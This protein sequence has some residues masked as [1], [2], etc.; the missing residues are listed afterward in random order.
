[1]SRTTGLVPA[2]LVAV[3]LV[4]AVTA[5]GAAA[6]TS[7]TPGNG[8][9]W[10]RG[11]VVPQGL[12]QPAAFAPIGIV[13]D[14]V[15]GTDVPD[16]AQARIL[17]SSPGKAP[18]S[19]H[20]TAHGTEVASVAAAKA[21]GAGVIGIAPGAP[22]LSYGYRE[23]TGQDPTCGEVADGIVALAD[24][25]AKVINLS[26]ETDADCEDVRL[27]IGAAYGDGVLVVAAAGNAGDRPQFPHTYP[28]DDPH[29]LTVGA[30]GLGL[31]PASFSTPGDGVDLVAPGE[32]VPVALPPAL[33]G[34]GTRDGLS[35]DQGTSFAA[36]MVAGLAS[37]LI[38]A[39]P[40]LTP[41]QYADLLRATA[42]DESGAGWDA[43]T[44]FGLPDL[45]SALTAKAGAADRYEPNDA[46]DQVNGM[47]YDG[48]DPYR[49]G[50][51]KATIAPVE[52]PADVY[53]IRVKAHGRATAA[54]T[55]GGGAKLY[56]YPGTA[57][58]FNN[59]TGK[60]KASVH[61]TTKKAK[62]YYVAVREP[63]AA[64]RAATSSAYTLK[65]TKR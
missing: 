21:D 58:R 63:A 30:L 27:A 45:A 14:P 9:G 3:A 48:A 36:P 28:A 17:A 53:R 34:D 39:R 44:G 20:V 35:V 22:L 65:L 1:M 24:A 41:G 46:I 2:A 31:Q 55:G 12:Q 18:G 54:L 8:Q 33:D 52:D 42:K 40:G 59:A 29:V 10:T 23:D 16:V 51:L 26:A 62:T 11:I 49:S 38:A 5:P 32:G 6:S 64:R 37:W 19:T 15:D 47:A 43:K 25:H 13:D 60:M 57:K 50:T 61:N 7:D 4:A 56:A